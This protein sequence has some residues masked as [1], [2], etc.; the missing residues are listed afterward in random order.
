MVL[1]HI[2]LIPSALYKRIQETVLHEIVLPQKNLRAGGS[3]GVQRGVLLLLATH[4]LMLQAV[5]TGL[6]SGGAGDCS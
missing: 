6:R 2:G 5:L 4:R 3:Y 1:V